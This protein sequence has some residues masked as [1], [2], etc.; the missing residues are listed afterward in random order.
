MVVTNSLTHKAH[1]IWSAIPQEI[2]ELNM[3]T[4]FKRSLKRQMLAKYKLHM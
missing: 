4:K 3:H 2:K 1:G